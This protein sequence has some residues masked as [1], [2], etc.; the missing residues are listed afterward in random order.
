M[1][2]KSLI[3]HER[4]QASNT[5]KSLYTWR[6]SGHA[7]W[8]R[9]ELPTTKNQRSCSANT[10]APHRSCGTL[11]P[12]VT[13]S[14][15]YSRD[16]PNDPN[17]TNVCMKN[18]LIL[19]GFSTHGLLTPWGRLE[20]WAADRGSS[21]P[22]LLSSLWS[23]LDQSQRKSAWHKHKTRCALLA[24]EASCGNDE[25]AWSRWMIN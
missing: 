3:E 21:C 14:K 23:C 20:L 12:V 19:L 22:A 18:P 2:H 6:L 16:P 4:T 7:A 9:M 25:C 10:A 11:A 5:R 15:I 1:Q 13:W 8:C 24:L 17:V